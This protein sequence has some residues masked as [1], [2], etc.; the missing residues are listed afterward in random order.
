MIEGKSPISMLIDQHFKVDSETVT[1]L[2]YRI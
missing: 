1:K 2:L